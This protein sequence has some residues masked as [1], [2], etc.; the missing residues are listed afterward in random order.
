MGAAAGLAVPLLALGRRRFVVVRVVGHSMSPT[1]ADG[2]R[3][4]VVRRPPQRW[5][6]GEL[7]A[8]RPPPHARPLEPDGLTWR[9]KRL[10]ALPNDP[11]PSALADAVTGERVPPECLLVVGDGARSGDSRSFGYVR[12]GDVLG[13]GLRGRTAWSA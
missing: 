8:F 13:V 4:L 1:L 10:V 6:R 2:R 11:V 3:V 12:C 9:I 7:V 5:R